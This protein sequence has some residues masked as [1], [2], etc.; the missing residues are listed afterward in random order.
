M[1]LALVLALQ[2]QTPGSLV[3]SLRDSVGHQVTGAVIGLDKPGGRRLRPDSASGEYRVDS[4]PPG[5]V[6]VFVRRLG[7]VSVRIDTALA[8]GQT[9]RMQ[10]VLREDPYRLSPNAISPHYEAFGL[11]LFHRLT[12]HAADSNVFLSPA[13]AALALSMTYGG[14]AGATQTAM[15]KALGVDGVPPEELGPANAALL[16]SVAK[17][18]DVQLTIA[19]SIWAKQGVPFLDSFLQQTHDWYHAPARSV[20]LNSQEAVDEINAWVAGATNNKIPRMLSKPPSDSAVMLLLNAVYFKGLW[21]DRFDTAATRPHPFTLAG[22]NVVTRR[23]MFRFGQMEYQRRANFQA[24]RLPYRG[25]RTAM[26]VFLPDSGVPLSK[27]DASWMKGFQSQRVRVGFPTF[28]VE[29]ETTL[30]APLD[31]MGM[32][33]AFDQRRADF[34]GMLPRSYLKRKNA[35]IS[36]VVQKTYVDVDEAGT[37]AAASTG[38]MMAQPTALRPTPEMI[39]DRPFVVAIRDDKTGLLLFLGQITD[40]TQR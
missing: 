31:A 9:L 36:E 17:R 18:S 38:A 27:F 33:V 16:D 40:P 2:L 14:S 7:Y 39:V 28:R 5:R 23:L 15:A 6:S 4:V 20:D 30:N 8:S 25:G 3:V 11:D 12:E 34:G 29:Y 24:V 35:F 32:G 10:L 26:Y 19:N 1:V 21:Q 13:S 22:G 37:E